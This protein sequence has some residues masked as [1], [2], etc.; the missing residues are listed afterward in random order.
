MIYEYWLKDLCKQVI[1][2]ATVIYSDIITRGEASFLVFIL[3]ETVLTTII[4]IH[5]YND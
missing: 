3:F 4:I 2:T 5:A 1:Y